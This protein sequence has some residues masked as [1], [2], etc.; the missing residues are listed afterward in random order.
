MYKNVLR[1]VVARAMPIRIRHQ[2]RIVKIVVEL[3]KEAW[4]LSNMPD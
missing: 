2:I 4:L 1:C 3:T